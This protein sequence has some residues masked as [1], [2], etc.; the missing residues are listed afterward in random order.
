[1]RDKPG[2]FSLMSSLFPS[3]VSLQTGEAGLRDELVL[4]SQ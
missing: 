3:K 4:I 1:M 2:G